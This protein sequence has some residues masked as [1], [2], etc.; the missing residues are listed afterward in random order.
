MKITLLALLTFA[1]LISAFAD[2]T[3]VR[4]GKAQATII[5]PDGLGKPVHLPAER[6]TSEALSVALAAVEVADYIEKI[7]GVRP[8]IRTESARDAKLPTRLFIGP[9]KETVAQV[10][11]S[12]PQPEEFIIR[13]AGKDVHI[14]GGDRAPG[15]MACKGTLF[16]AYEFIEGELGVRWLFPG[17]H[18]EVVPKRTTITIAD[19]NRREQPRL[20]KRKVR[21]VA[22]SREETYAP[23]LQQWGI[24]LDAWKKARGPEVNAPWHRRLRLG[25]RI[26]INGGHAYAGWWEK[27][28]KEHPEWFAL[29]PDGTRTQK[30]ERERLC[31]S[32]AALWDEIARVRINEFQADPR[33]R[34][35]SLAPN[36]GGANKWC[37]CAACRALDPAEAPKLL[38]DRSLIDPATKLPFAEYPALTDRVFTFFNEIAKRVRREMP[39]RDLVAYAYSVYRTPPV[40][41]GP[42]EPN[43][44]IGYVGLDRDDIEAWSRIAPRLYLRPNDLGPAIDLGMPRNNAVQLAN[45]VKFAVEHKA[46]GFDF[47]NGHGNWSA[48]GLDYYVLCKALWN[49]DLDVRTTIADYCHA[50]YGPAAA[51]MQRYHDRLEKISDQVRA[52]PQLAAK[53]PHAARLRRYYSEEALT[54]LES[55]I[56]AARKTVNG[57]DDPDMHASARI[58]MA[59]ESVK[60]ARLITALLEVAH[61]KKSPLF[62]DRLAAVESFLKTKVLTPELAPLHSHRYLRM[63][64]AYAE[65]EVE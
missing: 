2:I 16:G 15:G 13:T 31:K 10:K 14:V 46:I 6:L 60:Y 49:P 55:E 58:E 8:P 18:G 22:V 57:S 26:E 19:L 43:L 33:K 53:S 48:H 56:V 23:V 44:I 45:A 5:V 30:P 7:T 36:D 9:C 29:Q 61:E 41:L 51:P 35:A 4:D 42:L 11:D 63:A 64:L 17:E 54:A 12:P 40:K 20:A 25:Q 32:N 3:L 24:A 65:R 38:N 21:D 28:G 47:D 34:M 1:P 27:H 59:A 52:D 39:D 50:A 37:M 62:T